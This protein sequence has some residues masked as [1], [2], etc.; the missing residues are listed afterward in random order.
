VLLRRFHRARR[1]RVMWRLRWERIVRCGRWRRVVRLGRRCY[2]ARRIGWV[3]RT[4]R[5][6]RLFAPRVLSTLVRVR[7][8]VADILIRPHLRALR[9]AVVI[10]RVSHRRLPIHVA[11]GLW[12][13][14]NVMHRCVY[15]FA[16]MCIIL[17]RVRRRR[18]LARLTP[19]GIRR[20]SL[21]RRTAIR[22]RRI[23][24]LAMH[25]P[26]CGISRS[27]VRAR[28]RCNRTVHRRSVAIWLVPTGLIPRRLSAPRCGYGA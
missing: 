28:L 20:R 12:R 14:R 5:R 1:R 15:R 27:G 7:W 19:I 24:W 23:V 4:R 9:V 8:S 6:N 13:T 21:T 10:V 16:G 17:V 18:S 2:F 3:C 22:I 11:P 25:I 26:C